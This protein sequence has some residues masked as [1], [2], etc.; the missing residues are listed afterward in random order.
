MLYA[1]IFRSCRYESMSI[2]QTFM[3]QKR[4]PSLFNFI[5]ASKHSAL[6]HLFLTHFALLLFFTHTSLPYTHAV[7]AYMKSVNEFTMLSTG[8]IKQL[9]SGL[10]CVKRVLRYMRIA[11]AKNQPDSTEFGI[12]LFI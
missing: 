3:S 12:F 5:L 9:I 4:I 2:F 7:V 6:N 1:I 10:H 8:L 11:N